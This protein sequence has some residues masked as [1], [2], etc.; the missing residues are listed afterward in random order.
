M[1]K[2]S[3][4]VLR[5]KIKGDFLERVSEKLLSDGEE[6][7][8]V[9]SNKVAIPVVDEDGNEDFLVLTFSIP[10]GSRDDNCPYDAYGEAESYRMKCEENARK[11]QEREKKKQEKIKRD[12]EYR[13]KKAEQKAKAEGRA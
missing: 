5:E 1:A 2:T 9:A 3:R 7:L 8:R 6:V 13:K 10:T 12:T 4:K 11:V